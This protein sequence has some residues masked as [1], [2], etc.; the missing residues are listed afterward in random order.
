[1]MNFLFFG[2]HFL[3]CSIFPW[4]TDTLSLFPSIVLGIVKN[5]YPKVRI[6]KK[7]PVVPPILIPDSKYFYMNVNG[8]LFDYGS[9]REQL[10]SAPN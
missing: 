7:A 5:P 1:M 2:S 8:G 4:T 10:Q 6:V 9:E 3:F